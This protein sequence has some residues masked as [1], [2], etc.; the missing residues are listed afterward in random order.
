MRGGERE[1]E[2]SELRRPLKNR[3]L[4]SFLQRKL[5]YGVD[6]MGKDCLEFK[7]TVVKAFL[8]LLSE[9]GENQ[10]IKERMFIGTRP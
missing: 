3:S 10:K 4:L 9:T 5:S 1:E 8:V 7:D 6:F 2:K